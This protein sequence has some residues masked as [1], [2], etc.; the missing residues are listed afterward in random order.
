MNLSK[1]S[2]SCQVVL[3]KGYLEPCVLWSE[4]PGKLAP[5]ST[6]DRIA[7]FVGRCVVLHRYQTAVHLESEVALLTFAEHFQY[8]V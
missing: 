1:I 7:H 2:P 4:V 3:L 5:V 8:H 6:V